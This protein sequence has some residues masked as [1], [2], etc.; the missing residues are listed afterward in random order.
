MHSDDRPDDG[1]SGPGRPPGAPPGA[2]IGARRHRLRDLSPRSRL[3]AA[4]VGL[5]L[6]LAHA[7]AV[8]HFWPNW[9]PS[10]DVAL[11][12]L[13]SMDALTSRL[14]LVGQPSTSGLY[15]GSE[16][17]AF[18][19]GP[20]QF[21][22]S[23]PFVRAFGAEVGMMFIAVLVTASSA[24]VAAWAIFRQLG[25]YAG[26]IGAVVLSLVIFT[27]GS[28]SLVNPISS[29][30]SGYPLLCGA[31]LVWCLLCGDDRLLPLAVVYLS[32]AGQ[33]HL[34]VGPSVLIL[35]VVGV[36]AVAW[37]WRR[38]GIRRDPA[39]RR[40]A[41]RGGGGSLLLGL[42]LW[43]P[44]IYQQFHGDPGN[45]TALIEFTSDNE[46]P[47]LGYGAAV[48]Q[49]AHTLG[50]PPLLG[51]PRLVGLDMIAAVGWGT[52]LTAGLVLVVLAVAGHR[53][54]HTHP[55]RARLVVMV[56]VLVVCG[57]VNGSSVPDSVERSRLTFY[58]WAW[59]LTIF[60]VLGLALA[61]TDVARRRAS[62]RAPRRLMP[63]LVGVSLV[64]IVVPTLLNS[65][66]DRYTNRLE[67]TGTLYPRRVYDELT[68]E[69]VAAGVDDIDGEVVVVGQ[70]GP[71]YDGT[72]EGLAIQLTERGLDVAYGG[73]LRDYV[74]DEHLVEA[75]DLGAV[76]IM[77]TESVNGP[78]VTAPGEEIARANVSD[79]F[80]REAYNEV[81]DAVEG[82][83]VDDI[84]PG[85]ELAA[86]LDAAG[87]KER[88]LFDE[89]LR[90]AFSDP[91]TWFLQR[92]MARF[93]IEYPTESPRLDP[94]VLRRL[95]DS[96]PESYTGGPAV[97]DLS[98]WMLTD[99]EARRY[100]RVGSDGTGG[101]ADEQRP[102]T[103]PGDVPSDEDGGAGTGPTLPTG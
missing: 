21:F 44:P 27:T 72:N 87:G 36:A 48:R 74:A 59:P 78:V 50:L 98:V 49:V 79:D 99:D 66:F 42:L 103:Q 13:R 70:G 47:A 68:D 62:E 28:S 96:F 9:V 30:I 97:T 8:V 57:L 58:H 69:I 89:Q 63:A 24:L 76:L 65:S 29:N 82:T 26:M 92:D 75:E 93:F 67:R 23:A 71:V 80:D 84:E 39:V 32:F 43:A 4:A 91:R 16:R 7:F 40:H 14:P 38:A 77:V 95:V 37:G 88:L 101:G 53:W 100:L 10:G 56:G 17:H 6:V 90:R 5:G 81:V 83:D 33:A 64:V 52:W 41:L 25:A 15:G 19:P 1:K 31:V 86:L 11:M 2:R 85:P 55:R 34:S 18:H 61:A 46:R 60:A 102:H 45:V 94:A 35:V 20:M 3:A 12:T 22:M 73:F 51:Q 54:K